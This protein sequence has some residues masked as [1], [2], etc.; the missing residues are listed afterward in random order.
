MDIIVCTKA[1]PSSTEVRINPETNTLMREEMELIINPFDLYAIEEGL[2]LQEAHGGTVTVVTMGPP[3]AEAQL[4]EALGMGCDAAV[5]LSARAFAGADTWATAYTL[6]QGIRKLGRYDLVLCGRQAIDGDTGQVGPGIAQQLG[7]PQMT[8]VCKVREVVPDEGRVCVERLLEEGREVV[9]TRLPAL[10]T[11]VKDIN[12]PR[13][14]TPRG[15][16]RASRAEITVWGPDDLP[17]ADATALGLDGSPTRVIRI[18][19]PDARAGTVRM[20]VG[21]SVEAQAAAL[22]DLVIAD[23]AV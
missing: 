12:V 17:G 11:V 20:M 10:L 21:E 23:G 8:Y 3:K 13:S 16:R 6:A 18:A 7:I 14:P 19:T 2:R 15:L 1:V 4:R 9:E 5:L 22:A